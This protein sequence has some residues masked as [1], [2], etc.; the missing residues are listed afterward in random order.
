M[1]HYAGSGSQEL[2]WQDVVPFGTANDDVFVKVFSAH[3]FSNA[4][5]NSSFFCHPILKGAMHKEN[6]SN[7]FCFGGYNPQ[8]LDVISNRII[9]SRR[10][11]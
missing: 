7:V 2:V 3:G 5:I 6:A 4:K 10:V 8:D 11:N 1:F 9:E